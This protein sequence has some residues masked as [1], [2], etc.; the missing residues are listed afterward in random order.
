MADSRSVRLYGEKFTKLKWTMS[1][2]RGDLLQLCI[3]MAGKPK[4]NGRFSYDVNLAKKSFEETIYSHNASWAIR[5]MSTDQQSTN[6]ALM[7][8]YIRAGHHQAHQFELASLCAVFL[9]DH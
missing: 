7:S 5:A 3:G 6:T 2:K 8:L 4:T 1:I 9:P